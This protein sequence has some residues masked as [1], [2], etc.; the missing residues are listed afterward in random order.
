MEATPGTSANVESERPGIWPGI[1]AIVL[2]VFGAVWLVGAAMDPRRPTV[3]A[4]IATVAL[5]LLI[6]ALVLVRAGARFG[7][8]ATAAERT[9]IRRRFALVNALQYG[10]VFLLVWAFSALGYTERIA[11]GIEAIVGLHFV[12]LASTFRMRAYVAT[13]LAMVAGALAGFAAATASST[14][15]ACVSAGAVLWLSA[16]YILW[17]F[18]WLVVASRA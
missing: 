16:I 2:T 1:G 10:L 9:A 7:S 14:M 6:V 17:R 3:I 18:R 12:A 13:G 15:I 5:G 11:A 8:T 4:A